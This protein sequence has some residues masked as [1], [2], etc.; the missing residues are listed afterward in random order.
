MT[1]SIIKMRSQGFLPENYIA[2]GLVEGFYMVD[3]LMG[4]N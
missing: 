3:Q 4:L 1:F 2:Y